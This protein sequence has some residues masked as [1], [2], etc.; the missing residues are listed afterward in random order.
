MALQAVKLGLPRKS[1]RLEEKATSTIENVR[2][3]AP[4]L[5]GVGTIYIVSNGLHAHRGVRDFC[6]EV[7]NR[8]GQV[9]PAARYYPFRRYFLKFP[10]ALHEGLARLKS[11]F[12]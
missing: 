8:C 6:R 9:R 11:S 10:A 2:F 1:I 3:S 7:P 4:K 12:T 5:E